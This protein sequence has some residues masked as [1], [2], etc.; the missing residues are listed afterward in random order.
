MLL[1]SPPLLLYIP[2]QRSSLISVLTLERMASAAAS[3][4]SSSSAEEL[5]QTLKYTPTWVVAAVCTVIVAIS[6]LAERALY[7]LGKFLK[8]NHH[9]ALY[10]ALQKL[11]EELMLLGFISLLM[12]VFQH[13][14]SHICVPESISSHMLP[15][16]KQEGLASEQETHHT[17][18]SLLAI[19]SRRRL[20]SSDAESNFCISQGKIPLLSTEALEQLHIFI[21]ILA[22]VHVLFC[23]STMVLAGAKTRK[24]KRWEEKIRKEELQQEQ[25]MNLRHN[26]PHHE[27]VREHAMGL[28]KKSIVIRW[29]MAF[30]K[31]FHASVTKSDYQALRS[32]FIM[33]HCSSNKNFDFHKYMMRTLEDDFKLIVGIRWYLWLFVMIYLLLNVHGWHTFFWLSFLPLILLLSVGTKLEHVITKLAQAAAE[34]SSGGDQEAP[35][36]KPSN[37]HFWFNHP[38][39][40]LHVIHF[41]LFQNSFE[42]AVLIWKWTT[43]GFNSCNR[44]SNRYIAPRVVVV[45]IVQALCSYSTLPLYAIVTQMGD[46]FKQ[47]LFDD[48]LRSAL[49]GWA[50]SARKRKRSSSGTSS[51]LKAL[52]VFGPQ[53]SGTQRQK[54]ASETPESSSND[55]RSAA[56]KGIVASMV[57]HS[58]KQGV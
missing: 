18:K 31:Q 30:F 2:T 24:W 19:R 42:T 37:Q 36:I 58:E 3:S 23:V 8:H 50:E 49:H 15:C 29:T 10:E 28:A 27:F 33:R 13:L 26:H 38:G 53:K 55:A 54:M 7:Y 21:F 1:C 56:L 25:D 57:Q 9:E 39:A 40:V 11:K 44:H 20:L 32:G 43:Y 22:L 52:K 14:I 5:W 4:S 16:Q 17:N 45:L 48:Q 12:T 47:A 6:L 51:F 46:M 34:K 41:I 35:S